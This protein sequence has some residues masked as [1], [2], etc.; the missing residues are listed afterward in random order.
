MSSSLGS[1]WG[2]SA[3][4]A[5]VSYPCKF[6]PTSNAKLQV[7][8]ALPCT[9]WG[10]ESQGRLETLLAGLRCWQFSSSG[11]AG[12]RRTL[13]LHRV[14]FPKLF[15]AYDCSEIKIP[16]DFSFSG[17]LLLSGLVCASPIISVTV[18]SMGLLTQPQNRLHLER[19][20]KGHQGQSFF[21]F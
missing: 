6:V 18:V 11:A 17:L 8:K 9:V 10:D 13:C 21:C 3:W 16:L 2:A 1:S 15:E 19:A 20:E 7:G 14:V 4:P 12:F 5:L